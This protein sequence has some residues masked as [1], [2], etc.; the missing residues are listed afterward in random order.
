[1]SAAPVLYINHVSAVSDAEKSLL[2]LLSKLE[3]EAFTPILACPPGELAIC[4]KEI[5][6]ETLSLPLTRFTQTRN[7]LKKSMYAMAWVAGTNQ[8]RKIIQSVSPALI[9]SNSA[10]AHLYAAS[11]AKKA[12][13]PCVWHARDLRPLPFPAR[14]LCR[15]TDRVIAISDAVSTLLISSGL[16]KS[17]IARIYNGIDP[18]ACCA[19]VTG[20]DVRAALG[21]PQEARILLIV[22]Q[23]VPWK[24]HE[25][26]IRALP[27]IVEKEPFARLVV[28]RSDQFDS[29]PELQSRLSTLA[30]ELGVKNKVVFAGH[31]GDIPDLMAASEMLIMPSDAEPFGLAAIEAMSLGKPVVGTRAGGLP[32]VVRDGETGLLVVPRFPESLAIACLRLLENDSLAQSLGQAGHLR[33]EELFHIERTVQ[34]TQTLYEAM[35]HPPL[36]WVGA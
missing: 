22:A 3:R 29:H 25:D 32:E 30:Q 2:A 27:Q 5:D 1:M 15:R 19:Q 23:F 10:T 6:V 13:I 9:H 11:L 16:L 18:E 8:L 33:V 26:A 4:A 31:R 17:R 14:T 36:K 21:I 24:R 12:E 34:E 35:L 20:S 28:V 7:P